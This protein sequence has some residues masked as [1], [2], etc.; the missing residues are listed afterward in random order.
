[1]HIE[2]FFDPATSTLLYLVADLDQRRCAVID[3]ALDFDQKSGRT[4]TS[5]ADVIVSRL[6]ELGPIAWRS[7]DR[8]WREQ[9][10]AP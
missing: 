9:S 8:S 6:H 4:A 2:P 5:S 10:P 7:V 1:M 3:S